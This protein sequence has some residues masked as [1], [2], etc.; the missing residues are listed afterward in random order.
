[1][2]PAR[3]QHRQRSRY[4]AS[5]VDEGFDSAPLPRHLELYFH[6]GHKMRRLIMAFGPFPEAF[7]KARHDAPSLRISLQFRSLAACSLFCPVDVLWGH[8]QIF[9]RPLLEH[10]GWLY[11]LLRSGVSG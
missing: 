2:L 4:R 5:Q 11:R 3:V 10:V 9:A 7:A 8:S 1:M 6:P